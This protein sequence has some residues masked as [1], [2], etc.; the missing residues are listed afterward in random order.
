MLWGGCGV[1][2]SVFGCGAGSDLITVNLARTAMHDAVATALTEG[3][4]TYTLPP[5]RGQQ[6]SQPEMVNLRH[7]LDVNGSGPGPSHVS[8]T[9]AGGDHARAAAAQMVLMA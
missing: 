5:V 4:V 8:P 7:A 6:Q 2:L 1:V 3:H 9:G